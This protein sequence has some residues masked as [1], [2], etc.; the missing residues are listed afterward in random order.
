M[1]CHELRSPLASIQNAIVIL[2]SRS[3]DDLALQ[4]RMHELVERQVRQ[5]TLLAAG[6]LDVSQIT[7][8]RLRL[9]RERVDLC[10]V[11]T[12]RASLKRRGSSR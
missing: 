9:R 10:V 11:V 7:C 8:D 2:R 6:L 4:H 5:M 12:C 1:L 3:G